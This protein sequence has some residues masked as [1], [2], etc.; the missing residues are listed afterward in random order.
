MTYRHATIQY[1]EALDFTTPDGAASYLLWAR[2]TPTPMARW[3]S[4]GGY[5]IAGGVV[6]AA[7]VGVTVA[8]APIFEAEGFTIDWPTLD[9]LA[10]SGEREAL[11]VISYQNWTCFPH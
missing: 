7:P 9:L 1:G 8:V 2:E 11:Q 10:A 4:Q 6:I 5:S 3:I